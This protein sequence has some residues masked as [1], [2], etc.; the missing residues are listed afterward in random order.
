[1]KRHAPKHRMGAWFEELAYILELTLMLFCRCASSS[2]F[3]CLPRAAHLCW[4]L[5]ALLSDACQLRL[6]QQPPAVLTTPHD[7]R[8]VWAAQWAVGGHVQALASCPANEGRVGP[9]GVRLNLRGSRQATQ[10]FSAA[11]AD[12]THVCEPFDL[13]WVRE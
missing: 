10:E 13:I 6:L 7:G 11:A 2:T 8:A 4:A 3:A 12:L 1:M 5:A 9:V